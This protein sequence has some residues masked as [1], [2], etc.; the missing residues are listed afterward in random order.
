MTKED[1]KKRIEKLKKE[2]D[3][4]RYLY[5]VLDTQEISDAALDSLKHELFKLEQANPEFITPDSPTQRVGGEP[6]DKFEKVHHSVR[7]LSLEDAFSKSEMEDWEKRIMKFYPQGKYEYFGELKIDGFAISLKYKN[8]I[9]DVASTRGDGVTGENVTQNI[10]TIE[11]VPL[12][13]KIHKK[14]NGPN[15]K[16]LEKYLKKVEEILTVGEFEVRGEVYMSKK[17]FESINKERAKNGEP[18]YANPRNTAAGSIRQLDPK[19]SASR[20]L[21]FLAYAIPTDFGQ[22]EHKDEHDVLEALGFKTDKNA[23]VFKDIHEL[24][25]F[26]DK[27]AQKREKLAFQID[28][29]VISVNDNDTREKLGIVGKAPRGSIAFKFPAEESTTVVEGVVVQVGRTGALTPVAHLRPV[30]I[31]GTTVSRASLHNEDEIKRLGL[32]IGDTVIVQRAG[33]VIPKVTKVFENLRTGKEKDFKMP[34]FCPVCDGPVVK[35]EGEVIAKCV[36]KK[37]QAKNREAMYH[38]TSKKAFD[39]TGLG[40]KIVD[41][42]SDEGL[43]SDVSDIFSLEEGDLVPV[44]RFAE[45]SASNLISSIKNKKEVTLARFLYSLGILHVGEET[46][47]DLAKYFSKKAKIKTPKDI[48]DIMKEET[49]ESLESLEDIGPKVAESIVSYFSDHHNVEFLQKLDSAGIII[50]SPKISLQKQVLLGKIIVPTGELENFT[51]E[52]IKEKIRELGGDVSSSVSKKTDFVLAGENAGSKYDK[53]KKLGV[54]IIDEN[55]FLKM[56]S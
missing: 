23:G 49:Q 35:K 44:E 5:H 29:L 4:H 41:K 42:L 30:S 28:G 2:I 1:I 40:P 19:I 31:G 52:S 3:H 7:M 10:K 9:L 38:F 47:I 33:D 37:C 39:I 8:G 32:K 34:K 43:I 22:K 48:L 36:N 14:K 51:R 11:S 12:S 55:E 53:A 21:D 26:W 20:K 46:S 45:K 16:N 6:L 13:L 24:E 50:K 18:L 15:N 17:T 25:D 27:V 56:I 54:K